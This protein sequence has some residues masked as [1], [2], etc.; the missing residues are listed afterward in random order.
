MSEIFNPLL[1]PALVKVL[2]IFVL[3]VSTSRFKINLG[4][5]LAGGGLLLGLWMRQGPLQVATQAAEAVFSP[6]SLRLALAV[7]FMLVLSHLMKEGGQLER[8]VASFSRLVR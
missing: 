3:V 4:F 7:A 1:W 6:V 8:I 2:I 5:C